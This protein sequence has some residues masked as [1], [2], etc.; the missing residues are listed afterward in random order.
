MAAPPQGLQLFVSGHT[1]VGNRDTDCAL[2]CQSED[3][4][5]AR[6]ASSRI[7]A[8][9]PEHIQAMYKAFDAVCARLQLPADMEDGVME[10]ISA[11]IVEIAVAGEKDAD[12]LTA[13]VLAEFGI[14]ND[15]SLW[16]H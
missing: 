7:F 14:E 6:A 5:R 1:P 13:R 4:M 8:F 12:R 2:V 15:G 3:V 9:E 11:K 16:R 10:L